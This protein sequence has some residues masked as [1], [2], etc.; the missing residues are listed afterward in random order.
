MPPPAGRFRNV[1]LI[2][3]TYSKAE[4]LSYTRASSGQCVSLGTTKSLGRG[5]VTKGEGGRG[6]RRAAREEE[7]G[8]RGGR[9]LKR[10]GR[11]EG[12]KGGY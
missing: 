11:R 9:L 4:A 8:T 10:R 2:P 12:Q 1:G 5:G 3:Q 6:E 7:R